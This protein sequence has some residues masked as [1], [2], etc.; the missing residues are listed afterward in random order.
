MELV[1]ELH[2]VVHCPYLFTWDGTKYGFETDLHGQGKLGIFLGEWKGTSGKT[3]GL[4][5][6]G[7]AL[8]LASAFVAAYSGHLGQK[9]EKKPE[10]AVALL[11]N[12]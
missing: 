12:R 2:A 1:L 4:L 11:P 5:G 7:L 8:L 6:F 10:A 3:R 9:Q